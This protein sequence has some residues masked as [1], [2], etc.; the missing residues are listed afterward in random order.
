MK[1][2]IELAQ[3]L[4]ALYYGGNW[5]SVNLKDT[6]QGINW[7]QATT[8]VNNFNTIAKLVFHIDYFV[9]AINKVFQEGILDAHDKYSYDVPPISSKE[10]WDLLLNQFWNNAN[11]LIGLIEQQPEDIWEKTFVEDKYKTYYNNVQGM[12]EHTHYHLGQIVILKALI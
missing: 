3:H 12:I 1:L 9:V 4:K 5:T 8:P 7:E 2:S 11:V 10:D 6:L